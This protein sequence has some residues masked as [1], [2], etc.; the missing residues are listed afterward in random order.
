MLLFGHAEGVVAGL[1]HQLGLAMAVGGK[2]CAYIAQTCAEHRRSMVR[3]IVFKLP[4]NVI[5]DLDGNN[6]GGGGKDSD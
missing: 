6:P 2:Y 1:L 5:A 4:M 3:Y